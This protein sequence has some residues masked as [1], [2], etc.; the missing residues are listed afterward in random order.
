LVIRLRATAA[1]PKSMSTG[2]SPGPSSTLAG[3]MSRCAHGG[4]CVWNCRMPG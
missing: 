4:E 2:T 3:L 1:E